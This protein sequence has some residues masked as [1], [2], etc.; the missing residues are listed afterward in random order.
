[1]ILNL[2]V[3][4]DFLCSNN[5]YKEDLHFDCYKNLRITLF[6][7]MIN[8]LHF[9]QIYL[10]EFIFINVFVRKIPTNYYFILS[11][12]FNKKKK[13]YLVLMNFLN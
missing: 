7:D 6:I 13:K 2:N 3:S 8:I 11:K 4:V 5:C 1:M 10:I 9:V 12:E